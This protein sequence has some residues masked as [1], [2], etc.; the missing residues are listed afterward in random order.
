MG[1]IGVAFWDRG[2]VEHRQQVHGV[3]ASTS[4]RSEV[5]HAIAVRV[6]ERQIP[7]AMRGGHG[8]VADRES[9]TWGS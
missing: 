8:V 6:G 1:L 3:Q 4:E 7:A 9:R 2:D 5:L